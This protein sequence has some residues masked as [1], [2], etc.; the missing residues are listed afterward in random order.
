[1]GRVQRKGQE[2]GGQWGAGGPSG[3]DPAKACWRS[4]VLRAPKLSDSQ[5][6]KETLLQHRGRMKAKDATGP[7][8]S[9]E[10]TGQCSQVREMQSRDGALVT[11]CGERIPPRPEAGASG[12][13]L[14]A[15]G[16]TAAGQGAATRAAAPSAGATAHTAGA[17]A[18]SAGATAPGAA[19]AAHGSGGLRVEKVRGA[20]GEREGA[21]CG[22]SGPGARLPGQ[23]R[24]WARGPFL[25]P[26]CAFSP[27]RVYMFTY[28]K[29]TSLG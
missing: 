5:L 15:N 1:M 20:G 8:P 25:V 11:P 17:T 19:R 18:P 3:L 14:G 22:A 16:D 6:G 2:V 23:V 21:Q 10:P 13:T 4:Q 27:L 24:C 9:S 28:F 12:P 26:I 29:M 7:F